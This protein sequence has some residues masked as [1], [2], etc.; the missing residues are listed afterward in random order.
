VLDLLEQWEE[1]NRNGRPVTPK[2][3]CKDCP[4]LLE[5]VERGID[6]L[7]RLAPI[8]Q[9]N[10]SASESANGMGGGALPD[11]Q[12]QGTRFRPLQLHRQGGQG[13]VYLAFDS[14]L[15]R[16]VALKRIQ[17][18]FSL[19]D[20]ARS[21]FLR[22]AE[23][24]GRLEH[25]GIVPVYSLDCDAAGAPYYAMRFIEGQTLKDAVRAFHAADR[26]PQRDSGERSLAFRDLLNH[27]AALCKTTAYAHSRGVIHRDLKPANVM[28]GRFGETLLVDWGLAKIVGRGETLRNDTEKTLRPSAGS[29]GGQTRQGS[30]AGTPGFMSPEQARGAWDAIGPA[31]DVFS[32]GAT[33]YVI[34]TD[35]LPFTGRNSDD[36][37]CK[38]IRGDYAPPCQVNARVPVALD[39]ICR[40]AM[41]LQPENR[42]PSALGLARDIESW[43]AD[44][45]VTAHA[46]GRLARLLR[47]SRQHKPTVAAVVALLAGMLLMAGGGLGWLQQ[48][49][50]A[51]DRIRDAATIAKA[52]AD[53]VSATAELEANLGRKL[54]QTNQ[55]LERLNLRTKKTLEFEVHFSRGSVELLSRHYEN[56]MTEFRDCQAIVDPLA[57]EEA[58]D[59]VAWIGR[60]LDVLDREM[61]TL[62]GLGKVDAKKIDNVRQEYI[63]SLPINIK[64]QLEGRHTAKL[65]LSESA[66]AMAVAAVLRMT[67]QIRASQVRKQGV[68][69]NDA[70]QQ[71]APQHIAKRKGLPTWNR[72]RRGFL[73][74]EFNPDVQ[75]LQIRSVLPGGPAAE[76]GLQAGDLI[77]SFD[78][79]PTDSL[80]D[81]GT[82]ITSKTPGDRVEIKVDR[83]GTVLGFGTIVGEDPLSP[84]TGFDKGLSSEQRKKWLDWL[85]GSV[86]FIEWVNE[87]ALNWNDFLELGSHLFSFELVEEQ[88]YVEFEA[89]HERHLGFLH[90]CLEARRNELVSPS[91]SQRG[92]LGGAAILG[93]WFAIFNTHV[94]A[95][96]A[97]M[98]RGDPLGA[99]SAY[100]AAIATIANRPTEL[101]TAEAISALDPSSERGKQ[102][103]ASLARVHFALAQMFRHTGD[104][105]R[106][107][108]EVQTAAT[109][110][111][112][113]AIRARREAVQV[114]AGLAQAQ[115]HTSDNAAAHR[116]LQRA[117]ALQS[118]LS[119][120]TNAA[121]DQQQL[122]V[123]HGFLGQC[124][125]SDG[126]LS[127]ARVHF[128]TAIRI[129][130]DL[131]KHD[132]PKE[133]KLNL[134][135]LHRNL[136]HTLQSER[137]H[138]EAANAMKQAVEIRESLAHGPDG[139]T[140][141]P[142]LLGDLAVLANI[143]LNDIQDIKAAD[144]TLRRALEMMNGAAFATVV[145]ELRVALLR[146]AARVKTRL[147]E[148]TSAS[149]LFR[150]SLDVDF[151]HSNR[152]FGI[153]SASPDEICWTYHE[154]ARLL[155]EAHEWDGARDAYQRSVTVA[156]QSAGAEALPE[157][158]A[159]LATAWGAL[160]DFEMSQ[161]VLSAAEAAYAEMLI[162]CSKFPADI[163]DIK[164]LTLQAHAFNRVG[165]IHT[166]AKKGDAARRAFEKY[167]DLCRE[168]V[169]LKPADTVARRRLAAALER[170]VHLATDRREFDVAAKTCTE[171]IAI[172]EQIAKESAD[173]KDRTALVRDY[174]NTGWC[175]LWNNQPGNTV[176]VSE[177]G[178]EMQT[179]A[180]MVATLA[181][182]LAHGHLFQGHWAEAEDV[183]RKFASAK[184]SE[185]R[186]F[187]D[188]VRDDFRQFREHGLTHPDMEKVEAILRENQ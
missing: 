133:Q 41:A 116:T 66:T 91:E 25:P 124:A 37:I 165:I 160:A 22:E 175:N 8:L 86:E 44:E 187:A 170:L 166:K 154:I 92:D 20:D 178:M 19:D 27:F 118:Q 35:V 162:A 144:A 139:E 107:R 4:E 182:N 141:K 36:V 69:L 127:A 72:S 186:T 12:F 113:S 89:L 83:G 134:A 132:E 34:L 100:E 23:V 51:A 5:P 43:M 90:R 176:S 16:N 114:Y 6:A 136:A 159:R 163:K 55:E 157:D 142:E 153:L 47:W 77:L 73:G 9:E 17:G 115:R 128:E 103:N 45:A 24:T 164:L 174:L 82:M 78:N 87:N 56:A 76:A 62:M 93:I 183:Y 121:E 137:R 104:L 148:R 172:R 80:D 67:A 85:L 111:A 84:S 140:L 13:E 94:V 102:I 39:A 147:G 101:N 168:I 151:A 96:D 88:E 156:W 32:L 75:S 181:T 110:V 129:Q 21:R 61:I 7:Q 59:Q 3:L 188:A 81:L 49:R 122:V 95:G 152:D 52:A 145:P 169:V 48:H 150:K 46:E 99:Q 15:N 38:V 31:S 171:V 149:E 161:Q 79:R 146:E 60:R 119:D 68:I 10:V 40:K 64:E 131:V 14:E 125:E 71:I 158:W 65:P 185:K 135:A 179:S 70:L 42:Y 177:K 74:V 53:R 117:L 57:A 18:K 11:D 130:E 173:L 30:A 108:N 126:D 50:Q 106:M 28:L 143:Y 180:Q 138:A 155:A 58:D 63:D 120:E 98:Q 167:A 29:D 112:D 97:R 54:Q 184:I 109:L 105:E 26:Q 123:L 1:Q 33:L 2:D